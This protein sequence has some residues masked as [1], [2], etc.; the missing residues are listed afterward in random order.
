MYIIYIF[1]YSPICQYFF[2]KL[3]DIYFGELYKIY[4]VNHFTKDK[5]GISI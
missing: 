1:L 5:N 2:D 4:N 3:T